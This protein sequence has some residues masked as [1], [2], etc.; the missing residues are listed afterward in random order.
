MLDILMAIKNNNMNKIPQYDQ[1]YV[2]HLNKIMKTLIRKG[3]SI[4][5]LNISL[6]DLLNSMYILLVQMIIY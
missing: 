6:E 2:E 3:N 5:Q 1:S 4:S